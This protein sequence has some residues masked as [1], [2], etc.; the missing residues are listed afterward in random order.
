MNRVALIAIFV[1]VEIC[2]AAPRER[3]S[4]DGKD[5]C[6]VAVTVTDKNGVTAPRADS[7]IHFEI[8]GRGEIVATDNGGS[9]EFRTVAIA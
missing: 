2:S 9:H 1:A 6:F 3:I 8:E 7:R 5:L 4:A